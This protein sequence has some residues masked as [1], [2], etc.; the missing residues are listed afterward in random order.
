MNTVV[1]RTAGSAVAALSSLKTGLANVVA[2]LP[3]STGEP[4][5]RMQ[6][7]GTWVYGQ[8]DTEV[9]PGSTWAIN[10]FSFRHGYSSWTDHPKDP[11]TNKQPKNEKVGEVM[12][13]MTDHKPSKNTLDD[14]GWEWRDQVSVQLKCMS[15]EDKGE[16]VLYNTTALG[17]TNAIAK[18]IEAIQK[19]L[20]DDDG[21]PVPVIELQSDSYNHTQW[22]KTYFPIM[23]IVGWVSLDGEEMAEQAAEPAP[24][25]EPA[26]EPAKP[27]RTRRASTVP[28]TKPAETKQPD[29]ETVAQAVEQASETPKQRALRMLAEAEAEEAA[30]AAAADPQ[31]TRALSPAERAAVQ[32]AA[33][34]PAADTGVVRRRRNV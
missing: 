11:R 15:G 32:Q 29:H 34:Q 3:T 13:A 19:Q 16:Q 12:V 17:G 22:G 24:A 30:A 6:K 5:L 27:S 18:L 20:I 14:T 28:S 2:T 33:A 31:M 23:N 1:N 4:Y 21:H 10:I 9:E 7:D 26:P 25:P 8:E